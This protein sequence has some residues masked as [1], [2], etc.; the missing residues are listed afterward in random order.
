[1]ASCLQLVQTAAYFREVSSVF[2]SLPRL[3]DHVGIAG[4][5]KILLSMKL[6]SNMKYVT[7]YICVGMEDWWEGGGGKS[8]CLLTWKIILPVKKRHLQF[9]TVTD[10][11]KIVWGP[12][13]LDQIFLGPLVL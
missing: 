6:A 1:M 8:G 7:V 3:P 5:V 9:H 4:N 12:P 13:S 10:S 2:Y 11:L